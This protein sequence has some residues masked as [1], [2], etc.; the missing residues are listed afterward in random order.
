MKNSHLD[1]YFDDWNI[2]QKSEE[3]F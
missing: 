3:I 1:N 2:K